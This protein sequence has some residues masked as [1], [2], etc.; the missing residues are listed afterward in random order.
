[1][2][3]HYQEKYAKDLIRSLRTLRPALHIFI[4]SLRKLK[5]KSRV[6]EKDLKMVKAKYQRKQRKKSY[7]D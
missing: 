6:H 4:Q 1:M 7:G 2:C 3:C 5:H